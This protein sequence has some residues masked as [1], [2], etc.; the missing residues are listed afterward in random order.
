MDYMNLALLAAFAYF[1]S[2]TSG[3]LE[4]TPVNGAVV[5]MGFGL[6]V[7]PLGLGLLDLNVDADGL[8]SIAEL[9][10]AMV[11]FTDAAN[12][13][14]GVLKQRVGIPQRLLL[15]GL[16]LTI[17]LGFGVGTLVFGGLTMLEI[18]IL[19]T[20][21][22]VRASCGPDAGRRRRARQWARHPRGP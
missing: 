16:P 2:V 14:L 7:G 17:L 20:I 9:T 18:A 1:Y 13:D 8:R 11:L 3:K 12:A 6:I 19:A 10:L 21:G 4:R 22:L 5:F 15:I